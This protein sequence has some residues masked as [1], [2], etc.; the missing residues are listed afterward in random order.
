MSKYPRGSEWRKWDL[1]IHS[2]AS[3]GSASPE[4]IIEEAKAKGL[5]VI[6]LTDH[7]TVKNIDQIKEIAKNE[8]ITVISGI[9]FRSEYGSKSVHFIGYFPDYYN[10][11]ELNEKALEDLILSK[12]GVSETQV[13][14]KG[15]EIDSSANGVDAFK[16]GMF[17]VQV[18]FKEASKLIH[19]HGGLVAVHNGSKN[20]GLDKEMKHQGAAEKNVT[21]LYDSLGTVKE[22]LLSKNFINICEISK[23]NDSEDFYLE[24][25]NKP[26]IIT[27]DAHSKTEI[28]NKFVWIKAD[29]TFEGL[30]QIVYE[31]LERVRIQEGKP[32]EKAGYYVIDSIHIEKEK[33]WNQTILL[34]SNLSTIIGGRSA[35][36]STLLKSITKNISPKMIEDEFVS[37]FSDSVSVKWK[38]GESTSE[39]DIDYFRQNYM[40]DISK[41]TNKVDELIEKIVRDKD[42]NKALLNYKKFCDEN[43]IELIDNINTLFK[44]QKNIDILNNDLKENGDKKGIEHE[45]AKINENLGKIQLDNISDESLEDYETTNKSLSEMS[46]Q[47]ANLNKDLSVIDAISAKD[48][49]TKS[50]EYDFNELSEAT[51]NDFKS[52]FLSLSKDVRSK[53]QKQIE[54]YAKQIK[55]NIK[56][57]EEHIEKQKKIPKYSS[58][59]EYL[60]KNQYHKEQIARLTS[61]NKK[62]SQYKEL[63][64]KIKNQNSDKKKLIE[65]IIELHCNYYVKAQEVLS[66]TKFECEDIVISPQIIYDQEKLTSYFNERLSLKGITRQN[67]IKNYIKKYEKNQKEKLAEFINLALNKEIEYKGI[68]QDKT[69]PTVVSDLLSTNW[70]YI[71]YQVK[72]QNDVFSDMSQGKQAF[73][74]LK[75]L[76]EFSDKK[77]PILIDQPEDSL[78]NRAIYNELVIYLKSKKKERQIILATHNPNVV[79]GAD[80]EQVIVA[81][82]HGK[83]SKNK[84]SIKFQYKTGSIE[85]TK[86]KDEKQNIILESQ[87]IKEHICEILEGGDEAFIKRENKYGFK[88]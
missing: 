82:Q 87:G 50:I 51:R 66:L 35:G 29:P 15:K 80:A 4:E 11:I 43:R 25:F 71:T 64:A 45:I 23:E 22:E 68:Y 36:K 34:S 26:S 17:L 52:G 18:D 75:L 13:I 3:D 67:Y 38:D 21:E 31:P 81:N 7:H 70:F 2:N 76:L 88:N 55:K 62:L 61:E 57:L 24:K 44:L 60:E 39:R 12:L 9:E 6:A 41:D 46:E 5:S 33:I 42:E 14:S 28:G 58:I 86:K 65:Q 56:K 78:D 48:I 79:I 69:Q 10:G 63:E 53:W 30:K 72:Y 47:V 54:E 85:N 59:L 32:E 83:D 16:K 73:V 84:D 49:I 8:G 27:S 77:C 20:N 74:I 40:Y 37:G 1:H 19:Q